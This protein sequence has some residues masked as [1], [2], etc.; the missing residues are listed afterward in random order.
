METTQTQTKEESAASDI[1]PRNSIQLGASHLA[2]AQEPSAAATR[3][4][5]DALLSYAIQNGVDYE[6]LNRLLDLR[7]RWEAVEARKAFNN[8]LAAFKESPPEI[9]KNKHVFYESRKEG[10]PPTDYWHASLDHAVEMIAPAL[11]KHGMGFRWDIVQEGS[12]IKVTCVLTHR[13]GHQES[14]TLTS[15]PDQSGG[16]NSIQAIGSAV[17]YL[18]RYTLFAITGLAAGD[19]D[20]GQGQPGDAAPFN[21]GAA[22]PIQDG[23]ITSEQLGKLVEFI[24]Q[25]GFDTQAVCQLARVNSLDSLPAVKYQPLMDRLNKKLEAT[26]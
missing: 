2:K 22:N 17:T 18:Q 3:T 26:A 5:P 23:P 20:D 1:M 8:A 6:Q 14:V 11:A 16:K 19:D 21:Q 15:T 10:V 13:L 4:D 25:H 7:E 24:K 12:L 9:K